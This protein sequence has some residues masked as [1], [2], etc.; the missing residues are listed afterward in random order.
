M[1]QVPTGLINTEERMNAI[2]LILMQQMVI[3]KTLQPADLQELYENLS[4][5][6][7]VALV[8]QATRD[9]HVLEELPPEHTAA[10]TLRLSQEVFGLDPFSQQKSPS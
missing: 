7:S 1:E 9:A 2:S 6:D 10:L 5:K 4:V 8:M 3:D